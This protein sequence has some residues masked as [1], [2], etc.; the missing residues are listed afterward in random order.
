MFLLAKSNH[1]AVPSEVLR[2][3]D[4]VVR[5]GSL[6]GGKE[7]PGGR[8]R[9]RRR[10]RPR[11]RRHRQG[12][13]QREEGQQQQELVIMPP[14]GLG[15][16][17][18]FRVSVI[19]SLFPYFLRQCKVEIGNWGNAKIAVLHRETETGKTQTGNNAWQ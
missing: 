4:D 11:P 2:P 8:R 10:R 14:Q 19:S 18:C 9:R 1:T 13:T 17:H 15:R 16:K 7:P 6:H 5:G 3:V 12:G